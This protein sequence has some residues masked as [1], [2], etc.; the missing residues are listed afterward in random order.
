MIIIVEK[1]A[2]QVESLK[3]KL[4][5]HL[6]EMR[7]AAGF[8]A[9]EPAAEVLKISHTSLYELERGENWLSPMVALRMAHAYKVD[10]WELYN[11]AGEVE[12]E[13]SSAGPLTAQDAAE[14]LTLFT[15]LNEH[16]AKG[17]LE[18]LRERVGGLKQGLKLKSNAK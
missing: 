9:V 16:E 11:I 8:R 7:K 5:E 4:G 1:D 6:R 10:L 18:T 13:H 2:E 15:S 3:K 17:L 14:L 12:R